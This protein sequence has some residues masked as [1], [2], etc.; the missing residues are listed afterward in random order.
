M[1]KR[2]AQTSTTVIVEQASTVELTK[3]GSSNS[4]RVKVR[5][6]NKLL[7]TLIMGKGSVEWWPEKNKTN[8]LKKTWTGFAALLDSEMKK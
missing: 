8:C 4:V 7:G 1:A 2:K 5:R 3:K 6:G